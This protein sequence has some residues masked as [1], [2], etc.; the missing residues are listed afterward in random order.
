MKQKMRRP[1]LGQKEKE[2]MTR[3]LKETREK[4]KAADNNYDEVAKKLA[5]CESDLKSKLMW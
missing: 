2:R 3:L 4:A 1:N 5:T